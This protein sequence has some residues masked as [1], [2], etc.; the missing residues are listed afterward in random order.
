M[1]SKRI[2]VASKYRRELAFNKP[3]FFHSENV[4]PFGT[5]PN[6]YN[7]DISS[8][9][10]RAG[11]GTAVHVRVPERATR[12]FVYRFYSA[13]KGAYV[14][15]YMFQWSNGLI[16]YYNPD[17]DRHVFLSNEFFPPVTAFNYRLN[18]VDTLFF[19]GANNK[20]VSWNGRDYYTYDSPSISSM[21]LH[22]E[23]LFVTSVDEPTKVFFSDDLDPSNW[24]ISSS[25]AGFIELLDERGSLNK[26]VS[27]GN[28]L[29]IFRDH[30]ISRVTASGDQSEF[31]VTNLFVSA[32]RIYPSSVITCGSVI[33]FLASDGLYV[34]DGY[35][36]T[37]VL[38][39]IDGLILPDDSCACEY[40]DGKY[41]LACKMNFND[42]KKVGCETGEYTTNGLLV[43][44]PM[45]GEFSVSRGLNINYMH[46]CTY[47]GEDFLMCNEGGVGCVIARTG[48]RRG[49][50]LEKHWESAPT[51]F[52]SPKT[53]HI[54]SVTSDSKTPFTITFKS[55]GNALSTELDGSSRTK[56]VDFSGEVVSLEI[57]TDEAE[58]DIPPPTI[59]YAVYK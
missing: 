19:T 3:D 56:S 27:F 12:Y 18:S 5:S 29:Y 23:R 1:K 25:G 52:S 14:E 55:N 33:V 16:Q 2:P 37:R 17:S 45:S 41:Y 57:D 28:Y 31:S 40:F 7:F 35:E 38:T 34:F 22:Y 11:Y 24:N 8:G 46:T 30:G 15:Q 26:V 32:G 9:A 13:K 59:T 20:L 36:C 6:M 4:L 50:P 51:D 43:Y 54:Q 42:G 39:Q 21:A 47:A 53:K 58:P 49:V 10:L 44:T 48:A